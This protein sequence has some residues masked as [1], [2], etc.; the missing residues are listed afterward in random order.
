M[1]L[2]NKY[3]KWFFIFL[4]L[5]VL[6]RG[7]YTC[8]EASY[9]MDNQPPTSPSK[10]SVSYR[11]ATSITL[12]WEA[13]KDNI[14]VAGYYIYRDGKK[15]LSISKTTYT[16]TSL[17]PGKKYTYEIR[18]YDTAGNVSPS[19]TVLTISTLPDTQSPTAPRSLTAAAA[20]HTSITLVWD[21]STDDVGL[22]GYELYCNGKKVATCSLAGYQRKGLTPGTAYTFYVKAI[23]LAGNIS[24]QSN[25]ISTATLP[26]TSPPS[27]PA[28][29]KADLVAETEILLSWS[30]STDN[31]KVKGYLLFRDG[32]KIAE[33]T[34]TS[35]KSKQLLPGSKHV[36]YVRAKDCVGNLSE[37]SKALSVSTL[38]DRDP[39]TSPT[40]LRS[41]S[42]SGSSVA[43]VWN[44]S[45]DNVK[46]KGYQI[47]CNGIM[48]G[49]TARTS[50]TVKVPI[51]LGLNVFWIVAYDLAGNT[52]K[53]SA[54]LVVPIPIKQ[55]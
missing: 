39:P 52:S 12:V 5:A 32:V 44:S 37:S 6:P 50:R 20:D 2:I 31:I 43:L 17:V 28:N 22:K 25:T 24:N 9:R 54:P 4:I 36:Y 15:I 49:D 1:N 29:L 35:Y 38:V 34:R 19:S 45:V 46:V 21:P 51:N 8:A 18:A 42:I 55:P 3:F 41:K 48:V 40:G 26:D 33:T 11:T 7:L 47:Y 16:N 27:I 30:P 23:D 10:L 13:S 53:M 14:K